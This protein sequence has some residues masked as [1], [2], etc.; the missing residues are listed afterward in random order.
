V[1][2]CLLI[3]SSSRFLAWSNNTGS[4]KFENRYVTF[5]AK[6]SPDIIAIHPDTGVFYGFEIKTGAGVQN[7]H[8]KVFGK[9]IL[10]RNAQYY[11]IRSIEELSEKIQRNSNS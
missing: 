4:I 3:L 11:V 1:K 10:K 5:G 9:E 6:G 2:K 7:K 8:Q